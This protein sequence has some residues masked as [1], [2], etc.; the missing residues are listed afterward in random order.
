MSNSFQKW[1]NKFWNWIKSLVGSP[2]IGYQ[3]A[4]SFVQ[5]EKLSDTIN[6]GLAEVK[7]QKE[8]IRK[9]ETLGMNT[10]KYDGAKK[11]IITMSDEDAIDY[12]MDDVIDRL[13]FDPENSEEISKAQ[14][15]VRDKVREFRSKHTMMSRGKNSYSNVVDNRYLSDLENWIVEKENF[16][17]LANAYIDSTEYPQ[18]ATK[19]GKTYSGIIADMANVDLHKEKIDRGINIGDNQ[20]IDLDNVA[21]S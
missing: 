6:Q 15:K 3:I 7:Y 4:E 10:D 9:R 14:H 20:Y 8:P 18:A 21:R 2:D 5:G 19:S 16:M 17:S 13:L 1:V 12:F 11:D